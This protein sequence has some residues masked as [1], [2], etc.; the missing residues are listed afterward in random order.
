MIDL[1]FI[2]TIF[3]GIAGRVTL[4]NG[5]LPPSIQ[6]YLTENR[7]LQVFADDVEVLITTLQLEGA[8]VSQLSG[9]FQFFLLDFGVLGK[10]SP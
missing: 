4:D 8:A 9:Q 6:V 7:T 10:F 5:H 2:H 1:V 3:S